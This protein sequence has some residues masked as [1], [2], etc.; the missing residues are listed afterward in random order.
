MPTNTQTPD[1]AAAGG[2]LQGLYE[3]DC[4]AWNALAEQPLAQTG[5][6]ETSRSHPPRGIEVGVV[7]HRQDG[8]LVCGAP[9]FQWTLDLDRVVGQGLRPL[10]T[11]LS[12]IAPRYVHIP[13]LGVGSPLLDRCR[14]VVDPRL[15]TAQRRYALDALIEQALA[16]AEVS[17]A[18][19]T[20]FKDVSD[21]LSREM[22]DDFTRRGF[23]RM[24]SLPS[25]VIDVPFASLDDYFASLDGRLR[26]ELRR[27][28]RQ[29]APIEIEVVD[30]FDPVAADVDRLLAETWAR[31]KLDLGGLD[32]LPAGFARC[33]LEQMAPAARCA[34]SRL[35]GEVVGCN[36][37]F[38]HDGVAT[39][40]LIGLSGEHVREYNL[41]FMNWLWMLR[42][43]IENGLR[44]LEFG[45]SNYG[46]KL[47]LGCRLEP[48]W[49]YIRH[50]SKAWNRF[51]GAVARRISL[52]NLD[53]DLKALAQAGAQP[54]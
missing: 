35:D 21:A 10:L 22:H 51:V 41:Y 12:R 18:H 54:P 52:P 14:I 4:A 27:K 43:A 8:R 9:V 46:L 45:Q 24:S 36:L 16:T 30:Q 6:I 49:I 44:R 11:G 2:K 29:S 5:F 7:M 19:M 28:Q 42:Y 39:A 17:G 3:A 20:L 23:T 40:F 34:V 48:S 38:V 53:P 47:R 33:L 37:F 13:I 50:R 25:A 1:K 26:S 31:R 15:D 32:E